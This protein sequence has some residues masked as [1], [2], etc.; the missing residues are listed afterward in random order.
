[1]TTL[2]C[3][4]PLNNNRTCIMEQLRFSRKVVYRNDASG[5]SLL[6]PHPHPTHSKLSATIPP[7]PSLTHRFILSRPVKWKTV[8]FSPPPCSQPPPSQRDET[9]GPTIVL[10]WTASGFLDDVWEGSGRQLPGGE[11]H[12][13]QAAVAT[14]CRCVRMCGQH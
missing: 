7:F 6:A 9:S 1:M 11:T 4:Q 12:F 5:C 3:I 10:L 8:E 13:P 14:C 2:C